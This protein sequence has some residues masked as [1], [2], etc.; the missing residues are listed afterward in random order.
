MGMMCTVLIVLAVVTAGYYFYKRKKA[1]EVPQGLQCFDEN[2]SLI[3]DLTDTTLQIFGTASTGTSNGSIKDSR[4]N[5]ASGFIF[6]VDIQIE[7]VSVGGNIYSVQ[8]FWF[9]QFTIGGGEIS[10]SY[11]P[12]A[13]WDKFGAN[14]KKAK[15]TFAYGGKQ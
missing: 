9:P 11:V 12:G 1:K 3:L 4:I 14:V 8:Y 2:G 6:P 15:I 13:F 5:G 7:G 10:W